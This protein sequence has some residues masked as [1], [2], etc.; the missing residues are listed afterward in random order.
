MDAYRFFFK[1][2]H[3]FLILI[4]EIQELFIMFPGVMTER[5]RILEN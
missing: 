4:S 3:Q 5:D 1:K 2:M